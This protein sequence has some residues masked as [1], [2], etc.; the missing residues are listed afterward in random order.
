MIL[1]SKFFTSTCYLWPLSKPTK[2]KQTLKRHSE[3]C[4]TKESSGLISTDVQIS[5]I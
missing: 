5:K 1:S 3:K 2:N 4:K